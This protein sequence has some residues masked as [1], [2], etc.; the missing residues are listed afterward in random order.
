MDKTL[1]D[2]NAIIIVEFETGCLGLAEESWTKKGGMDDRAEVHGSE[3]VAYANLLQGNSI[4]TYSSGGYDYAVEKAGT[5]RGWSFTIYEEEW[6]YGFHGEMAHFVDCV[7]HDK[8]PLVT[9]Y[10]A[11]EVLKVVFAAYESAGT[12]KKVKFPYHTDAKKPIDLWKPEG[13]AV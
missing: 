11:R 9:G 2:D 10:D 12:G 4:Y 1:G 3:G 7:Q 13:A 8:Q 6:N 5:T